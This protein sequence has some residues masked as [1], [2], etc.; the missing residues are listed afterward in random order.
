MCIIDGVGVRQLVGID[1]Q[2]FFVGLRRVA[3]AAQIQIGSLQEWVRVRDPFE[4][5]H[6]FGITLLRRQYAVL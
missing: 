5:S 1:R 3:P 2:R 6:R 4:R